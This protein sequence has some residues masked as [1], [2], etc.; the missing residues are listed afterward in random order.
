MRNQGGANKPWAEYTLK[1]VG[2]PDPERTIPSPASV[3]WF[4]FRVTCL[5][6]K[7]GITNLAR[8]VHRLSRTTQK[9]AHVRSVSTPLRTSDHPNE[10]GLQLGKIENLRRVARLLNG[11]EIK[12]GA[13]FSF[14]RQVGRLTI[15]RGFVDGREIREG[16]IVPAIGG[17]I[18]QLTNALHELALATEC[19][20]TERHP[21]TRAVPGV[22]ATG[23]D[24]TVAWNHIDLRF[25]PA[26]DT[27]LRVSL[28]DK[29][30]VVAFETAMPA[31]SRPRTSALRILD[32]DTG[33]CETCG[34]MGCST[35][36]AAP[37]QR[38]RATQETTTFV[39][40]GVTPEFAARLRDEAR[41]G[42]A[43]LLPMRG[44][45][46]AWP[47]IDG[48][49][50]LGAPVSALIRGAQ[51][52]IRREPP[53]Q[54]AQLIADTDRLADALGDQIPYS[55][56]R[57]ICD[58][59]FLPRLSANHR[60]GGREVDVWLS[61]FPLRVLHQLLDA[62][63]QAQ[64][65]SARLS[66]FRA[67][68]SLVEQEWAALS[69][70]NRLV[71]SHP[72]LAAELEQHFPGKVVLLGWHEPTPVTTTPGDYLYFPGPTAAREGAVAVREAALRLGLPVSVAGQNLDAPDFWGN[73]TLLSP[74]THPMK[75][76]L[77]VVHPAVLKNRPSLMLVAA[78]SGKPVISTGPCGV[79]GALTV[80]FGDV[81]ALVDRI[82]ALS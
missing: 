21:H 19:T 25:R 56:G 24:A 80:P 5:Q 45:S 30:L 69:H 35:H 54:R 46:Y 34:Q 11:L 76:S 15:R 51:A 28:T 31:A 22:A 20:I 66:D 72:W 48:V 44:R 71:T 77:C 59:N 50:V 81:D 10:Q 52:R 7:R 78:A 42:D 74:A 70:A 33:S 6:A 1:A 38:A 82:R 13:E 17:G 67:P 37:A 79:P 64:P 16:C 12:A 3:L 27:I 60:L 55:A 8:P 65:E 40:D 26:Q 14:W 53:E 73:C 63:A 43:V 61:R 68:E 2:Q 62:A 75:D 58:I 36:N 32:N 9:L 18:C 4:R 23:R 57:L 49:R 41:A 39:L 47:E 29:E